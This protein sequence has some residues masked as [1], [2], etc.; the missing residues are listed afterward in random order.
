M[1]VFTGIGRMTGKVEI[2]ATEK[3]ESIGRFTLA[4]QRDKDREEADFLRCVVFGKTAEILEK[5]TDK[6]SKIGITARVRTGSYEKDGEKKYT[7]DFTVMRFD[8]LD[9]KKQIE[10]TEGIEEDKEKDPYVD[11]GSNI[12]ITEDL[13]F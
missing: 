3:G 6:G 1:N 7:T 10:E 8:F 9:N 11:F 2:R 13:P 12:Q 4:I 5:H